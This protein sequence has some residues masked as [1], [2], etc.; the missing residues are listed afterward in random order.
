MA[1][2]EAAMSGDSLFITRAATVVSMQ[3]LLDEE[4]A[5]RLPAVAL[6]PDQPVAN[7]VD[8]GLLPL[9][10][11]AATPGIQAKRVRSFGDLAV[12]PDAD[13]VDDPRRGPRMPGCPWVDA[14]QALPLGPW[15]CRCGAAAALRVRRRAGGG[16]WL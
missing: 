1:L 2:T 7:I 15:F 14:F 9:V 11:F 13:H 16:G 8:G 12:V 4:P 6:T 10:S 3:Q 5:A